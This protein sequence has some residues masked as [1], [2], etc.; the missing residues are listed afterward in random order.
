MYHLDNLKRQKY[1][2]PKCNSNHWLDS[3]IGKRHHHLL[4]K[5]KKPKMLSKE[6]VINKLKNREFKEI[7]IDSFG[8]DGV[9]DTYKCNWCGK[10]AFKSEFNLIGGRYRLLCKKCQER[11]SKFRS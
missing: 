4:F 8:D 2:C 10:I 1:L 9:F 5:E 7:L 11:L 3:D 6:E